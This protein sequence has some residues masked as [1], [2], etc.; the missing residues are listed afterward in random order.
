MIELRLFLFVVGAMYTV[1]LGYSG[2]YFWCVLNVVIDLYIAH[3]LVRDLKS[4]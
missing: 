1:W 3:G 4:R 2:S